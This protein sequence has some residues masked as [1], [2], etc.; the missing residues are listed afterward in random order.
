MHFVWCVFSKEHLLRL[1][2]LSVTLKHQI[3]SPFLTSVLRPLFLWQHGFARRLVAMATKM[4]PVER[5]P[6]SGVVRAAAWFTVAVLGGVLRVVVLLR[7]LARWSLF[8]WG[9]NAGTGAN[10]CGGQLAVRPPD[11]AQVITAE[12]G[13]Q[14]RPFSVP[15]TRINPS[16]S[17]LARNVCNEIGPRA[18]LGGFRSLLVFSV[19]VTRFVKALED[20]VMWQKPTWRHCVTLNVV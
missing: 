12:T 3:A 8:R 14:T 10:M 13:R 1:N 4:G 7:R 9:S 18:W 11:A 19:R 5:S 6:V 20:L 16:L 17:H 2:S 15:Q